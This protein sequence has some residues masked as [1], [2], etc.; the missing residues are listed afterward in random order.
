MEKE[1]WKIRLEK[2][3]SDLLEKYLKLCK[4]ISTDKFYNLSENNRKILCSQKVVMEMY[5]NILSLRL[6]SNPDNEKIPDF[7]MLALMTAITGI[8]SGCNFGFG[9]DKILDDSNK[10]VKNNE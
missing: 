8:G 4:F 3:H 9:S 7:T 1:D 6:H 5:L 10:I 2:E